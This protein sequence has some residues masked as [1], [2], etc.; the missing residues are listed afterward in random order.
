M[1]H[2]RFEE[3]EIAILTESGHA[4]QAGDHVRI[5]AVWDFSD[6]GEGICYVVDDAV[7]CEASHLRRSVR[8]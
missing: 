1:T 5:T 8:H 6:L 2:E 4:G 7:T 3:G